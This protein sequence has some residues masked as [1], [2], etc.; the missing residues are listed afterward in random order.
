MA[1]D[2]IVTLNYINS[3]GIEKLLVKK[4]IGTR[5][6]LLKNGFKFKVFP[7]F[8]QEIDTP[9]MLY[10]YN[11]LL[12]QTDI[13]LETIS[14]PKQLVFE[15]DN[16]YGYIAPYEPGE[17]IRFI[18]PLTHIDILLSLIKKLERDIKTLSD[19]GWRMDDFHDANLL[20]DWRIPTIKAIDT[21]CYIRTKEDQYKYNL[22]ILFCAII[23]DLLPK[24]RLSKAYRKKI[25]Q[26]YF[27][28]AQEGL[29]RTS[30]FLELL[31]LELKQYMIKDMTLEDLRMKL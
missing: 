5:I 25:I 13:H 3:V 22:K 30:E 27:I 12:A 19:L 8:L 11:M 16:L 26:K 9:D 23:D 21:D 31:L 4:V 1:K 29:M 18:D 28:M 10:M 15:K 24:I 17:I 7:E 14:T 20:I 6:Y 2:N